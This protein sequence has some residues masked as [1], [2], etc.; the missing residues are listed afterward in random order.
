MNLSKN[1]V[2]SLAFVGNKT[3]CGRIL[4]TS[5]A[6][7]GGKRP[8]WAILSVT[9][10]QLLHL[11]GKLSNFDNWSTVSNFLQ[12]SWMYAA[13]THIYQKSNPCPQVLIDL[14]LIP[15]CFPKD[16]KPISR[17]EVAW[18]DYQ[19]GEAPFALLI[20]LVSVLAKAASDSHTQFTP[21]RKRLFPRIGA[22][23]II[24]CHVFTWL[25][26]WNHRNTWF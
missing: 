6:D 9:W 25:Q 20:R 8:S 14:F 3:Q 18:N 21:L 1:A 22:T 24:F 11:A 4:M 23:Y 7:L 15:T 16:E 5:K 13:D 26:R 10:L 19:N 17:T 2:F 12:V